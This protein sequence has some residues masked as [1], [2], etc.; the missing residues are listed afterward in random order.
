MAQVTMSSGY[1]AE[2]VE[3]AISAPI[4]CNPQPIPS[5]GAT[6]HRFMK[7]AT[8]IDRQWGLKLP[9][10]DLS[11]CG[12]W[13]QEDREFILQAIMDYGGVIAFTNQKDTIGP[14]DHLRLAL[15]FGEPQLHMT[16]K[17]LP[18]YPEITQIVRE[19]DADIVFGEEWH[20]DH[21]FQPIPASFSFLRATGEMS[22]H[23]TNNTQFANCILAWEDL[24]PEMKARVQFLW[25]SHSAT[26]AYGEPTVGKGARATN[27]LG[28]MKQTGMQLRDEPLIDDVLHPFVC[29]HPISGQAA[30]FVSTT[31]TN[32][33]QNMPEKEGNALIKE[34][35]KHI[36][37]E[38]FKFSVPHE[39]YQI[40]MWD[41]RQ[42]IHRGLVNDNSCRRVIQRICVS[43]GHKPMSS[44]IFGDIA[45]SAKK[46]PNWYSK[47]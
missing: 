32:G 7:G 34:Y 11:K 46:G 15:L 36:T 35:E 47:L 1:P 24:S 28:A 16:V 13:S 9:N 10:V 5:T 33:V 45:V 17:G 23:G 21:S 43:M 42:L 40:T 44:T 38:K 25:A 26:K 19:T 22:P 29:T 39:P 18:G 3:K 31:F 27:S 14:D 20:S 12:E 8:N 30:L 41:N 4:K 37:Q 2:P 6:P